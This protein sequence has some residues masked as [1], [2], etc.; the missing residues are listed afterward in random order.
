IFALPKI[1]FGATAI[2]LIPVC[3]S[4]GLSELY[5]ALGRGALESRD[6]AASI[7]SA[8][9]ALSVNFIDGQAYALRALATQREDDLVNA[10]KLHPSPKTY[11]ALSNYYFGKK[12]LNESY[13][14]LNKALERDP[15]NAPAL[16]KY[17]QQ[18]F[19]TENN[20]L[21]VKKANQLI[22][23][24]KSTYFTVRSQPEFVPTQSYVARLFLVKLSTNNQEKSKLLE[25]AIKGFAQYRDTT[26]PV[27]LRNLAVSPDGSFGGESRKTLEENYKMAID[28]CTDLEKLQRLAPR[29]LGFDLPTEA[30]KFAR[31]LAGLNK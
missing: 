28:A 19:E 4:V 31:A 20:E 22:D 16:L 30:T 17:L 6:F 13:N 29:T 15:N 18:A 7:S 24:E 12:M 25:E 1:A 26:G 23:A 9:S 8:N 2:L 11:R 27:I 3:L 21:V 10:T 5:R 14:A